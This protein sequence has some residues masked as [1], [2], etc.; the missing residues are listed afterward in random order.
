MLTRRRRALLALSVIVAGTSVMPLSSAASP[1]DD[2]RAKVEEITD[3][4]EGLEEK[5][6]I[7]AEE[8]AIANAR[9]EQLRV[10]I[11]DTEQRIAAKSRRDR[12][13]GPSSRRSRSTPT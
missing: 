5:A 3:Q 7:L 8:Y 11:A 12:G 4:L 13:C 1:I 9:L 2:Q 6:D 10:D